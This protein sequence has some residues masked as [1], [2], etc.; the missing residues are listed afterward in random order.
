MHQKS[1]RI[2]SVIDKT[3]TVMLG[4]GLITKEE[5]LDILL[6]DKNHC[7]GSHL[8]TLAD[9]FVLGNEDRIPQKLEKFR[10]CRVTEPL[11]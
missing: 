8:A 2:F 9:S 3:H 4:T 10:A 5:I 1:E 6:I 7:A 11:A